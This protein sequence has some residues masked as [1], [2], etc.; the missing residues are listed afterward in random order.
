MIN[1]EIREHIHKLVD[2]ASDTQLDA[3]LQLLESTSIDA[4]YSKEDIESFY[5]RIQLFEA[6]ESIGYSVDESHASIRNKYKQHG[7]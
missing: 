1:E 4:K 5:E 2:N 7:A 3:V 6:E